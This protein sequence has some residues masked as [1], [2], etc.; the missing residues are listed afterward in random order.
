MKSDGW[1]LKP[2]YFHDRDFALNI[3]G[4]MGSPSARGGSCTGCPTSA[5]LFDVVPPWHQGEQ[6]RANKYGILFVAN[7]G[8]CQILPDVPTPASPSSNLNAALANP[9]SGTIAAVGAHVYDSYATRPPHDY[10]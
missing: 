6:S 7:T 8:G 2:G 3:D 9:T 1:S 4:G 10:K 5:N